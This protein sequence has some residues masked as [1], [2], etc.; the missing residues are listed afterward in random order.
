MGF[1][2]AADAY[3]EFMGQYSN[4]LGVVFADWIGGRRGQR[5]I[6][7][8]CGTGALTT[9]LV[10]RL[11][12]DAVAAVDPSPSFVAEI[13]RRFPGVDAA[14]ASAERLPY[15][16]DRFDIAAAQLVVHFMTDAVAGIRELARVTKTGGIV[17]ANAWD[18]SGGRGPHA[19]FW[20]A[21]GSLDDNPPAP[22]ALAG[23]A[24]TDLAGL[25]TE[26]GLANVTSSSLTVVRHYRSF[27]EWWHPYTLGVAPAG[28]YVA[29]LS[30]EARTELRVRCAE[31]FPAT[32][33]DV[34]ALAWCVR[35][36]VTEPTN[37]GG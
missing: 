12:A 15:P 1:D 19:I 5:A 18:H 26:A 34:T 9:E 3:E 2:V 7:V 6:D 11:G 24:S 8:G 13:Q 36:T 14:I 17:A 32:S 20:S 10:A 23:S 16:D 35:G 28:D 22:A 37:V 29:S 33:F 25:F 30:D 21:V 4:P 27:D 31:Q